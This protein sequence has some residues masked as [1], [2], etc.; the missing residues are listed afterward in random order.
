M[1]LSYSSSPNCRYDFI[2]L[3]KENSTIVIAS[4]FLNMDRLFQVI[5]SHSPPASTPLISVFS[6]LCL[7]DIFPGATHGDQPPIKIA[8]IYPHSG[9]LAESNLNSVCG[10]RM[11]VEEI[12][13]AGGLP[14]RR[15]KT[16]PI[17]GEAPAEGQNT[18]P[19]LLELISVCR[20]RYT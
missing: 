9:A 20:T 8:A 12:N 1:H 6:I 18:D 14:G 15:S 19:A 11:A 16:F 5:F 2:S 13:A 3:Q 17:A 7:L 10:V 4:W